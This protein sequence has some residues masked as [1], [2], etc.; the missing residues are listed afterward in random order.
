MTLVTRGRMADLVAVPKSTMEQVRPSWS[1]N[2][3][4]TQDHSLNDRV[5]LTPA[6]AGLLVLV[7]AQ[8]LFYIFCICLYYLTISSS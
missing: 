2:S 4:D 8:H 1:Q 3:L 7:A 5:H 6:E